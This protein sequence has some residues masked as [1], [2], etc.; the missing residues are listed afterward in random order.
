MPTSLAGPAYI[1]RCGTCVA[2]RY[3]FFFN[4]SFLLCLQSLLLLRYVV[5]NS[6]LFDKNKLN[7]DFQGW[8]YIPNSIPIP[9]PRPDVP[10][11]STAVIESSFWLYMLTCAL[12]HLKN[13][14]DLFVSFSLNKELCFS[15]G[16]P[17]L[18]SKQHAMLFPY[19]SSC[20]YHPELHVVEPIQKYVSANSATAIR[21]I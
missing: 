2:Q 14:L 16:F 19:F 6:A 18:K 13:M 8:G 9:N 20:P 12:V 11:E 7:F 1:C 4:V 10:H 21:R 3:G 15:D 17:V 5:C